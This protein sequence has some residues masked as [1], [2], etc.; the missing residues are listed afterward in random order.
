[1]SIKYDCFAFKSDNPYDGCS[2]LDK[3]YCRREQCKFYKNKKNF[4]S[5]KNNV[6]RDI[7]E[8]Q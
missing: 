1:M 5:V 8:K 3:L 6:G 2:A 7:Y 4:E